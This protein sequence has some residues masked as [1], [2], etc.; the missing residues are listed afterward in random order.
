[1]TEKRKPI[2]VST[3]SVKYSSDSKTYRA[4][5]FKRIIGAI[6][7]AR[8][9]RIA[10]NLKLQKEFPNYWK[11]HL[12]FSEYLADDRINQQANL[13]HIAK[14]KPSFRIDVNAIEKFIPSSKIQFIPSNERY[15]P[16]REYIEKEEE[17]DY[18]DNVDDSEFEDFNED[19]D[20]EYV[21]V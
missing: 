17:L 12:D 6:N 4:N 8:R 5:L 11:S 1:M 20:D 2:I 16:E 14:F 19:P 15:L 10:K 21:L 9:N 3:P 7:E 13:N 18:E